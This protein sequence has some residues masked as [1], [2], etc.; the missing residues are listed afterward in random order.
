LA[1]FESISKNVKSFGNATLILILS[2][3]ITEPSNYLK[4]QSTSKGVTP[5]LSSY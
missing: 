1:F 5:V 3:K 4:I 2:K